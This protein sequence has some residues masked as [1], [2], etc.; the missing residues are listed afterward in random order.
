[1][2]D[3]SRW[4]LDGRIAFIVC[5]I[6][7]VCLL[8]A[9][10]AD[11]PAT[12]RARREGDLFRMRPLPS[13][14]VTGLGLILAILLITYGVSQARAHSPNLWTGM[15]VAAAFWLCGLY[16]LYANYCVRYSFNSDCFH[17]A[18]V[19]RGAR[20]FPWKT[21]EGL[22]HRH[23]DPILYFKDGAYRLPYGL[24]GRRQLVCLVDSQVLHMQTPLLPAYDANILRQLV[25]KT[26]LV[27]LHQA[28]EEHH[29][30]LLSSRAGTIET[31][32]TEVVTIRFDDGTRLDACANLRS[33]RPGNRTADWIASWYVDSSC[34]KQS[35]PS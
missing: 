8:G 27:N 33:I 18:H 20:T 34:I 26:G 24:S 25:G 23:G 1:V 13:H 6:A 29:P 7:L 11:R 9:R 4:P 31:V 12:H 30:N 10:L 2:Q 17:V 22:D 28:D 14:A 3:F 5:V 15:L 16:F 19:L 35:Q 32:G 21:L